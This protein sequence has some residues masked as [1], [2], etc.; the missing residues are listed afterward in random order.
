MNEFN[1]EEFHNSHLFKEHPEGVRY[2]DFDDIEHLH[3]E[4][5]T[6]YKSLKQS[7]SNH[8]DKQR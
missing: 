8:Q 3:E 2:P 7:S 6:S 1:F 5:I 4:K